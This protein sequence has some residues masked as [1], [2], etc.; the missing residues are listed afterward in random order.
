M[1]LHALPALWLCAGALVAPRLAAQSEPQRVEIKAEPNSE[2]EQRRRDP[3]AKTIYGRD[4]LDKYGDTNVS[5]VLKR[6]PGVNVTAGNPRLRGLGA[7]YTLVLINGEPAPPGFSLDNLSPSQ[8]ERIEVTKGPSAEHSAQ[9][10]AGT[11]N[12]ILREP[13][14]QRQRELRFGLNYAAIKPAPWLNASYGDRD[15]DFSYTLPLSLYSWRGRSHGQ[16]ERFTLDPAGAP[17]HLFTRS[18]DEYFGMGFNFGPRLQWK[19]SD[20]DTVVWQSF[21]QRHHF[22]SGGEG[23]VAVL[24]GSAPASVDDHYRTDGYWQQLR[25][26]LQLNRKWSDGSR[27]EVKLGVRASGNAGTNSSDGFDAAGAASIVRRGTYDI[28]EAGWTSGG[29]V[30]RPLW[31]SHSLALGW[32]LERRRRREIFGEIENSKPVLASVNG[33]PFRA[34]I[35]R[36]ALFVQDEW[37]LSPQWSTYLG[38]RSERIASQSRD[39]LDALRNTSTVTTPLWHLNYKLDPNGRDGVRAS[40]T[41][42]YRAPELNALLVRPSIN[43]SYPVD[44]PN[45]EI[46]PDRIG[47]PALEPELA[48]GLDLAFEHYFPQGGVM[49]LGLFQRS[50]DG[51]IRNAVAL[52]SVPWA[53]VPRWVS[54]PVNLDHARSTGIEAELKGRAGELMPE[55]VDPKLALNVRASISAYRS[56][57]SNLPTPYNRL[58]QQ[59]P[60]SMT[61]GFDHKLAVAFADLPLL[62]GATLAYTPGYTL[63]QTA[64]QQQRLARVRTLDAF[65]LITFSKDASL[66]V[67]VNNA[68]PLDSLTLTRLTDSAFAESTNSRR[69]ALA[70]FSAG[71]TLKF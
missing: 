36:A 8:V 14:R 16:S 56:Q 62:Y 48:T 28:H 9:A 38:L 44:K 43:P 34:L 60:W 59:Q 67:A 58:E 25:S 52:Q 5:D 71:L 66:R 29:K 41:R 42:S 49:S 27:I 20:G 33:L 30:N 61:L 26:N 40:L 18:A 24:A 45:P 63:Q 2:S 15:G 64:A 12:I 39:A 19:L 31:D 46:A 54:R 47:N 70:Q 37:E 1:R 7:G 51:L 57:V 65:A 68:A 22:H 69:T 32:D 23:I 11:I 4:E 35:D 55:W 13:P 3:V 6:L 17:Q 50:I 10:V 21:A 53:S